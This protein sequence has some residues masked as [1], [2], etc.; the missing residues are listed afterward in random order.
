M[1]QEQIDAL[2]KRAAALEA[3]LSQGSSRGGSSDA[4][5]LPK[6]EQLRKLIEE[7]RLE[8]ETVRAQKDALE[9]E[10]Q[11]LRADVE[12]LNYR[13]KHLLRTIDELEGKKAE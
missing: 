6:L 8:A 9:E 3:K 5:T 13:V 4:A 12:K 11:K 1:L 7:D 10:N 2:E